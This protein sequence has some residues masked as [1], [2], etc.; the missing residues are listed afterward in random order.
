MA[1]IR[2]G[3]N[4]RRAAGF[5]EGVSAGRNLPLAEQASVL[6]FRALCGGG[7][8]GMLPFAILALHGQAIA[9]LAAAW[10]IRQRHLDHPAHERW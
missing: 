1:A 7:S 4:K 2:R 8:W 10:F 9:L 3:V 6:L 5:L